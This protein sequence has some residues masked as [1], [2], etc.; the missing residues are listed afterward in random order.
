[1]R[2]H[3]PKRLT[4]IAF[5]ARPALSRIARVARLRSSLRIQSIHAKGC[6]MKTGVFRN[7]VLLTLVFALISSAHAAVENRTTTGEVIVEPPTLIALGFEWEIQGDDNR[8]AQVRV[9]YRKQGDAKWA[10]G[11]DLLRLQKEEVYTRGALDYTSPNMFSG[12]L[13]DLTENTDYEVKLILTDPDGVSG[14]T[15]KT[16]SVRTRAEPQPA[17]GG[18]VFHVYPPGFTGPK[19]QPAFSGLLEAYYMASLG[20]DWSRASPP[21][22]QAGDTV[23]MHAGVYLSKHDHYSHEINSKFTTCCG[24]P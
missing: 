9:D 15:E 20:G 16:L 24:T 4:K 10:R 18:R 2:K 5:G 14:E 23:L 17:K 13:F 21:R 8:N 11:L 19:E 3:T 12:S 1:M 6:A 22:V 7:V